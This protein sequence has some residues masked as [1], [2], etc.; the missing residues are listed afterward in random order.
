LTKRYGSRTSVDTLSFQLPTGVVGGFIGLN[1]AGETT[2][3]A[4]RPGLVS[5]ASGAATLLGRSLDEPASYDA[6]NG[7]SGA[8][9]EL[10]RATSARRSRTCSATSTPWARAAATDRQ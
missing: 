6:L 2:T 9:P 7:A 4:M 10:G 3:V 8:A 5:P 1:G